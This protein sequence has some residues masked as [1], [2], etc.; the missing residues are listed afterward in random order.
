M[1]YWLYGTMAMFH[2]GDASWKHWN[3][4]LKEAL[5]PSQRRKGT[6]CEYKGSW[7]PIGPW[8]PD[9]GRVYATAMCALSLETYYRYERVKR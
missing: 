4:E 8:G 6:H 1:Y 5:L 9:G 3:Y 2:V 7:D